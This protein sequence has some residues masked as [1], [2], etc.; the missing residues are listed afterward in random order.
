MNLLI[1]MY[2]ERHTRQFWDF[3]RRCLCK[4]DRGTWDQQCGVIVG[5]ANNYGFIDFG[6]QFFLMGIDGAT[7]VNPMTINN[8]DTVVGSYWGSQGRNV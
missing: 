4:L 5:T 8:A 2:A 6:G 1:E 3:A 7:V